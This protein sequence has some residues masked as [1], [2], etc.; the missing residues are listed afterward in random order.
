V[1]VVQVGGQPLLCESSTGPLRPI[2]PAMWRRSVFSSV[3]GLAHAGIQATRHMVSARYVWC[4]C[5]T[6]VTAWCRDCVQCGRGKV[7]KQEKAPVEPI[8]VP[9]VPFSH[10]HVDLVG[11]LPASEKG[12]TYLLTIVDRTTRWSE[13]APL[14]SITAQEVAD[15]FV[16]TWVARF[17]MPAAVT[18]DRGT[19]FTGS[20]WQCLCKT[21]GM[22]HITTTA[23]HPQANGMV[24]GF[25]RQLKEALRARS[26]GR[27]W[28]QH[29]PWVLLG[30]QMAPKEEAAVSSAEAALGT[31]LLL[32]GQPSLPAALR[33]DEPRPV[34]P[35]TTKTY[36][37]AVRGGVDGPREGD[38]LREGQPR[39]SLA[40]S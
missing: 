37:E 26:G 28:L 40:T 18:T 4:G 16:S 10:V 23:Y 35:N 8:P 9:A 31:P 34:L 11:P 39:G 3:H 2:V 38:W 19:Q 17:S 6:N 7:T 32:P 5:A 14:H 36:A 30:L 22:R 12:H 15:A 25:H 1:Q 29:L 24:E 21:L 20:T 13:V 27:E 33:T